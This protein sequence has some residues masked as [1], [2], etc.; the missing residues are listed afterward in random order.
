MSKIKNQ[1]DLSGVFGESISFRKVAGKVVAKN[2]PVRKMAD[3]SALQKEVRKKFLKASRYAQIQIDDAVTLKLYES[4][5]TP[6]VKSAYVVAI[7]DYLNAPTVDKIDPID[8][9]GVIGN[10]LVISA[11]DDFMVTRVKVT[12]ED[13][14]GALIEEG[15]AVKNPRTDDLWE[16]TATVANPM[17][18]GTKIT[19]VVFDNPGNSASLARVL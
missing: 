19:A 11:Y 3:P 10:K 17:L 18:P 2:R 6:K 9:R 1:S 14:A 8:Y 16:Y 7:N 12:I 4:R 5:I 15:D 13:P